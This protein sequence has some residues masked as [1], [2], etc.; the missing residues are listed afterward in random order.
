MVNKCDASAQGRSKADWL[1][2]EKAFCESSASLRQIGDAHGVTHTAI[3]NRAKAQG[4]KRPGEAK[5]QSIQAPVSKNKQTAPVQVRAAISSLMVNGRDWNREAV[6]DVVC[7]A[8]ASSSKSIKTV[9]SEGYEGKGLPDYATL[10]RWLEDDASLCNRYARAKEAQADFLAEELVELHNKAWVPVLDDLGAPMLDAQSRPYMVVDKSSVAVV[11][12]EAD[13]KKWL[14][15]KLK[16]KKYGSKLA[17]GGAEDLGP[18]QLN[19][20]LTDAE[21]AVRLE[22]ALNEAPEALQMLAGAV[23]AGSKA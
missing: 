21:R 13:N 6:M 2:I 17:L 22:R 23:K 11:K 16:P 19:R 1:A 7:N 3:R 9:L 18:L 14:M 15:E 5:S 20:D 4:W 8:L 12:L 10:S